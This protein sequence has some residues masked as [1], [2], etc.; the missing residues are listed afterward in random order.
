MSKVARVSQVNLAQ[1]SIKA[2]IVED[3]T[4]TNWLPLMSSSYDM[5]DVGDLVMVDFEG[6]DFSGGLCL[7]RYYNAEN[8]PP[9]ADAG[10][11]FKQI[12]GDVVIKYTTASKTLE[13]F[14]DT[15]RVTGNVEI[16]GDLKVSGKITAPTIVQEG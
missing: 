8:A 11:Y 12:G 10:V 15:V 5:P 9:V 14:A 13:V 7:G 2:V 1:G 4:V 3:G 16:T 6:G